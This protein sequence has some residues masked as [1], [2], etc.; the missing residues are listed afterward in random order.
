MAEPHAAF[1]ALDSTLSA[2]T[3]LPGAG[4][5]RQAARSHYPMLGRTSLHQCTGI[6]ASAHVHIATCTLHASPLEYH[7]P[8]K[9]LPYPP[10]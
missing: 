2:V 1:I 8:S 5:A 10:I 6:A 3:Q 4:R 9:A 7:P